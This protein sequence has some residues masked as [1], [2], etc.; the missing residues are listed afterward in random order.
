MHFCMNSAQ[1]VVSYC[2][3]YSKAVYLVRSSFC[4]INYMNYTKWLRLLLLFVKNFF[5]YEKKCFEMFGFDFVNMWPINKSF[6]THCSYSISWCT[7]QYSS[8]HSS[9]QYAYLFSSG[10]EIWWIETIVHYTT[11]WLSWNDPI[12]KY[13]NVIM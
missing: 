3:S 5:L 1:R 13:W 8:S 2:F 4:V 7:F 9:H 6:V 12:Y 10:I 11:G